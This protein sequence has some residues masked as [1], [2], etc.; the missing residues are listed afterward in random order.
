[1]RLLGVSEF[2]GTFLLNEPV[3]SGFQ[4]YFRGFLEDFMKLYS[5][6]QVWAFVVAAVIITTGAFASTL[7]IK[8][9]MAGNESVPA[10]TAESA[11]ILPESNFE[12]QEKL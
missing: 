4:K 8:K 6:H 5:K 12:L 1:M 7:Y 3:L 10:V 11:G 9:I 2:T